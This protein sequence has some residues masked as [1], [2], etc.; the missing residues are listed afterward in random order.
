VRKA[1]VTDNLIKGKLRIVNRSGGVVS[2]R[3][4]ASD[5]ARLES[6]RK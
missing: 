5:D 3:D 1:L 2:L 4:N 6:E